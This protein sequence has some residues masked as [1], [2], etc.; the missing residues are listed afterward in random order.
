MTRSLFY[1]FSASDPYMRISASRR[2]DNTIRVND[3][4][5]GVAIYGPYIPLPPGTY[6]ATLKFSHEHPLYGTATIDVCANQGRTALGQELICSDR[7]TRN[8]TA[9]AV[10]FAC[11]ET[12][13]DVE[14]RLTSGGGFTA[15][16]EELE[17]AG[18]LMPLFSSVELS[19]LPCVRIENTLSRRRNLYDGSRRGIGLQFSGL[20]KKILRDPDYCEARD[21]AG[22][23]T[24]L[25]ELNLSNFFLI[26]KFYLPHLPEG[27]IVE[28]GSYHGGGVIFM[29]ALARKYLPGRKVIGFDTFTGMP[30]TDSRVDHHQAGSFA[31]VDLEELRQYTSR[32]GLDN[33]EFV[34]G[35][36]SDTAGPTLQRMGPVALAHIDCDIRSAI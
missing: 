24:I 36:F 14:V 27:H 5:V 11:S 15:G 2:T 7:L 6:R 26:F 10:D 22:T 29:A 20:A 35:N 3:G 25:G 32:L 34:Q 9:I 8:G 1:R 23:R 12:L 30:P 33:L 13:T 21:L 31:G 28:F 17:I 4:D 16:I 19:D 18:E